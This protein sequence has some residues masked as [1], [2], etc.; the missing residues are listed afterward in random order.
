MRRR[1]AAAEYLRSPL[2]G[3][4]PAGREGVVAGIKLPRL[5]V[6]SGQDPLPGVVAMLQIASRAPVVAE[7]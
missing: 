6:A 3:P 4:A 2:P 1:V 5:A 7:K